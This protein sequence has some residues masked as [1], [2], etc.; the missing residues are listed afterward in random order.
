MSTKQPNRRQFL[1]AAT[2]AGIAAGAAS[3]PSRVRANE[4]TGRKGKKFV[5]A[6]M[7]IGIRGKDL[8]RLIGKRDDVEVAYLAEPDQN[9]WKDATDIIQK[10]SIPQ[11]PKFVK[12][13]RTILDDKRIDA[14][15]NATPD[16][17][18]ALGTIS[19][20][21]AGK[22]VYSEKP[23]SHTPWEGR[24]MVKAARKY[25]RIVQHGTHTRSGDYAHAAVE[26]IKSG[27]L[28]DVHLAR[29]V[30]MKEWKPIGHKEDAP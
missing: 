27:K 7:G 1:K 18:H 24:Q 20:C 25:N 30:N 3:L 28:G 22:D 5:V 13:F 21:Q 8:F 26:Y 12:D 6:M 29:I 16:H 11:N 23:A 10:E 9:R 15:F 4:P 19:A 14:I 2:A 17:W